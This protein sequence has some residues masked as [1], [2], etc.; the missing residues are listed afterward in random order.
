[1]FGDV[2]NLERVADWLYRAAHG[3]PGM[4]VELAQHLIARRIVRYLEGTWALPS[5]PITEPTPSGLVHVMELRVSRLTALARSLAELMSVRRGGITLPLAAAAM[6]TPVDQT[7]DALGELV[8]DGI[9]E[10]E[11]DLYV[12]AQQAMRELIARSLTLERSAALHAAVAQALLASADSAELQLEA[13]W[14]L[15]H[16]E[17]ELRGAEL[18]ARIAPPLLRGGLHTAEAIAALARAHEVFARHDRPLD[19]RLGLR[20]ELVSAGYYF[21]YRLG[22][23]Y[24]EQTLVELFRS[25]GLAL[26]QRIARFIPRPVA[27]ALSVSIAAFRRY[28]LPKRE[29]GPHPFVALMLFGRVSLALIGL[30]AT[31]LDGPGTASILAMVNLLDNGLFPP[32]NVR[33]AYLSARAFALQTLGREAELHEAVEL[34]LTALRKPRNPF[35]LE[36]DWRGLLIG[37]LLVAGV[38]ESYRERSRALKY[39]EELDAM[40]THLARACAHR[41]RMI[42]YQVR[43]ARDAAEL[44]RRALDLIAI[45]GGTTWQVEWFAAPIEGLTSAVFADLLGVRRALDKL[46]VLLQHV[47]SL[48]PMRDA[49]QLS[50]HFQRGELARVVE[51]GEDFLAKHPPRTAIGWAPTYA[52]IIDAMAS[53]GRAEHAVEIA[54]RALS[55]LSPADFEYFVMYAPLQAASAWALACVDDFEP[56][57]QQISALTARFADINEQSWLALMHSHRAR[58]AARAGNHEALQSSVRDL[59]LASLSSNNAPLLVLARRWELSHARALPS[60]PPLAAGSRHAPPQ[61]P[62]HDPALIAAYLRA[63]T[64][65]ERYGRALEYVTRACGGTDGY[66]YVLR[67]DGIRR[68]ATLAA[69]EPPDALSEHIAMLLHTRPLPSICRLELPANSND[70]DSDGG[71]NYRILLLPATS[72]EHMEAVAVLE[73]AE[74]LVELKTEILFEVSDAFA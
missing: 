23:Q 30:R 53:V 25:S 59:R 26:K 3:N 28:F 11:G 74:A 6:H 2:P 29:R 41:V 48:E 49:V 40:H 73:G 42:H 34:A 36:R 20:T 62:N 71:Q 66:L 1:M 56:A 65:D 31:A 52:M 43:G 57:M 19:V 7:L 58:I 45:Q 33:A 24:G 61:L 16:T 63:G 54:K 18:L 4:S 10:L 27:T 46:N 14:H 69:V 8:G 47:P 64:E 60:P 51:L 72:T 15:V 39:A 38:N 37:L 44:E 17:D 70:A 13:A 55:T 67:K 21:D 9:V 5:D 12:F 35:I 22:L 32:L 50:Y 68:V